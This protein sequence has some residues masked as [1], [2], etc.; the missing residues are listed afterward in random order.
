MNSSIT[1]SQS[2]N[3]ALVVVLVLFAVDGVVV[4][5]GVGGCVVVGGGD[6]VGISVC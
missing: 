6:V 1:V 5:V 4:D 3:A 2:D